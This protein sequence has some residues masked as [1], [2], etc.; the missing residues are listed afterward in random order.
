[1]LLLALAYALSFLDRQILSLLVQPVQAA[2][3]IDDVQFSLLHGFAFAITYALIGIPLAWMSDRGNRKRIIIA[4]IVL[5]S[6]ATMA[7]GLAMS[8]NQLLLA[9]V[10]VGVGEAALVPA[11]YS[12]LADLFLPEER[13]RPMAV[14][15]SGSTCGAGIA[16]WLGGFALAG[17]SDATTSEFLG[18]G[19]TDVWR[20]TFLIVG[21]PGIILALIMAVVVGEPPRREVQLSVG[22]WSQLT[23]TL[24]FLWSRWKLFVPMYIGFSCFSLAAYALAAWIPE[25]FRRVHHWAPQDFAMLAG[26]IQI[27]ASLCGALAAGAIIDAWQKRGHADAAI[28]FSVMATAFLIPLMLAFAWLPLPAGRIALLAVV[29]LL[30][31]F[32]L[33]APGVMLQQTVPPRRVALASALFLLAANLIGMGG[34][35]TAVAL[36]ARHVFKSDGSLGHAVVLVSVLGVAAS[37]LLL[38]LARKNLQLVHADPLSPH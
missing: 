6:L 10:L 11:T 37:V 3:Q 20:L 5:W 24:Q 13:A 1:M 12:L 14:F 35:P 9:R 21:L 30:M 22:N 25:V 27:A 17:A 4:G 19:A 7:C 34:G 15:M 38:R 8:F 32:L 28:R 33:P 2:L 31:G 18:F 26:P 23:D 16:L 36:V 29:W